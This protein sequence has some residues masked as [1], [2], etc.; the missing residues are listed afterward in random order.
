MP[1]IHDDYLWKLCKEAPEE[2]H[3]SIAAKG[4]ARYDDEGNQFVESI[5][6]LKSVDFVESGAQF[7]RLVRVL[8]SEQTLSNI[9]TIIEEKVS[10]IINNIDK[11]FPRFIRVNH[12]K[13]FIFNIFLKSDIIGNTDY[14]NGFLYNCINIILV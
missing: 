6:A 9:D 4:K 1:K 5:T 11:H 12:R 10:A 2:V 14:F 7:G 13:Q 3:V 8:E